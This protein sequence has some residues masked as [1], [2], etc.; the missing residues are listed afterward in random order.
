ML[1][2]FIFY[3]VEQTAQGENDLFLKRLLELNWNIFTLGKCYGLNVCVPLKFT[4]LKPH[5]QCD[6]IWWW[7]AF[8]EVISSWGG[9]P[10]MEL[11]SL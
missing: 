8:C 10:Q 4:M 5:P 1:G 2:Y 6:I 3:F 7:G 11:V 9:N